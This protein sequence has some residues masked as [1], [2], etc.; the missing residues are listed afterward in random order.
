MKQ[1]IIVRTLVVRQ[2]MARTR[3]GTILCSTIVSE[4]DAV[5]LYDNFGTCFVLVKICILGQNCKILLAFLV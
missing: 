2:Y 5:W 1:D 3:K 4:D